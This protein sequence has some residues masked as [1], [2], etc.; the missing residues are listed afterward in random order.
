VSAARPV[1]VAD[2]HVLGAYLLDEL[3]RRSNQVFR[4]AEDERAEVVIPS[5][6]IAE[7]IYVYEKAKLA[8]KIWD[9]FEM[10]DAYPSFTIQPLDESILKIV[11]EIKLK[12]LHDRIIVATCRYIG[13]KALL[14]KDQEIR[15]SRLVETIYE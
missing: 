15:K 8:P 13:A 11:P 1:F 12:E 5:V 4:D 14:T 2:A 7:L 6:A 9:M 10:F 3:P